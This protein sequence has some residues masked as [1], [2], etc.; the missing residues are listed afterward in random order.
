MRFSI[1]IPAHNEQALIARCLAAVHRA[2]ERSGHDAELVVVANR[3]TDRTVEI[4]RA[5]GALVVI[6]EHRNIAAVRNAG[7]AASSGEVVVTVDADTVMH[8]DTLRRVDDL[9]RSRVHVGGGCDFVP[10]RSSWGIRFTVGATKAATGL[11]R[12]GGVVY[13]CARADFD[14]IGGFD[15]TKLVGEDLDFAKR[16]RARGRATGRSFTNLRGAPATISTRKFDTFGDWHLFSGV[17]QARAIRASI[18]GTDTR[19]VDEYF[20]DYNG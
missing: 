10:E 14:A 1:I 13:W 11:A 2:V 16:L 20:F 19:F 12:L 18:K 8:P 15:E 7:V 6:D 3:C 17:L 5:A 9:L 4:A